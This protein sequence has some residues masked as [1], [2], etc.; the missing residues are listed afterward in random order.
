MAFF[1]FVLVG[2]ALA[3]GWGLPDAETFIDFFPAPFLGGVWEGVFGRQHKTPGG[4]SWP[5]KGLKWQSNTTW[6]G[7]SCPR[8]KRRIITRYNDRTVFSPVL[9]IDEVQIEMGAAGFRNGLWEIK[10]AKCE[11]AKKRN[12]TGQGHSSNGW[13]ISRAGSDE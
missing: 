8:S 4:G 12:W 7:F 3:I 6:D 5:I 11:R 9:F 2:S 13:R 10:T 1:G